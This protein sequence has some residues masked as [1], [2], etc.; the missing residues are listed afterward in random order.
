MSDVDWT[1]LKIE[2]ITGTSS[3]RQMA[4]E[5]GIPLTSIT[6]HAKQEGWPQARKQY[7][8]KVVTQSLAR[9]R[10]NDVKR[11]A[12]LQRAT[13]KLIS[14]LEAAINAD[15]DL[16]YMHAGA[17]S[18]DKE[19]DMRDYKLRTVN[20]K[21]L[22]QL[23]GAVRDLTAAMRDLYGIETRGEQR[24]AQMDEENIKIAREKLEIEKARAD[25]H[26][27]REIEIVIPDE[28]KDLAK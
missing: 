13:N 26:V 28:L 10:A 12:G 20:G 16:I 21:N 8:D 22:R 19:T 6:R 2:Y 7:K 5:H 23:A 27:D 24:K 25:Q 17:H 4:E 9:A 1:A 18:G 15:P 3:Y 11:L 14:K